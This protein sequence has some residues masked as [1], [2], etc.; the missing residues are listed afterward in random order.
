MRKSD[1]MAG[2]KVCVVLGVGAPAWG[3]YLGAGFE[4]NFDGS[5]LDMRRW[6][7]ATHWIDRSVFGT[8]PVVSGGAAR[9]T[10]NTWNANQPGQSFAGTEIRTADYYLPQPG[11]PVTVEFDM[12]MNAMRDGLV[13]G[14]FTFND[15]FV[16]GWNEIDFELLSKSTNPAGADPV[17]VTSWENWHTHLPY[18]NNQNHISVT[19][20][21]TA[22]NVAN[23][24]TYTFLWH[25]DKVEWFV[26]G[27]LMRTERSVVSQIA[28]RVH[29]N[30][31]KTDS[32]GWTDAYSAW[33]PYQGNIYSFD[34][35]RVKVIAPM[36]TI[37]EPGA[38]GLLAVGA[39]LLGRRRG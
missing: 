35:S 7:V 15:A 12:K 24:N 2:L 21:P 13:V 3:Q 29:I 36:A 38:L 25:T 5:S 20:R 14:L 1:V 31:W 34:V 8:V 27:V 26:N 37:P 6:E 10:F 23:W 4:D 33:D 9:F 32:P 28:Q 11:R 39:G 30:F 17:L 19:V 16:N 22:M 18:N